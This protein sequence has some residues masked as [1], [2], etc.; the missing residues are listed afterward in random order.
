M[1]E[2][3]TIYLL[4][5]LSL[6]FAY[7]FIAQREQFCFSGGIKDIILFKH[8]RR[9]ASL[10]VAITT[11][12]IFTQFFSWYLGIDF[13]NTRYFANINYLFIVLGGLLFGYG[14]MVSDGCSSR[15]LIKMAQGDKESFF[16]LIALG[17]FAFLT[18][19]ILSL[20]GTQIYSLN[21]VKL[22][23]V[24][25]AWSVP[26]LIV[27]IIVSFLLYKSLKKC[28]HILQTWDGFLIGL[29]ITFGWLATYYFYNLLFL[30]ERLQSL[31]F[32]YPLG[33]SIEFLTSGFSIEILTMFPVLT[34]IGV[35]LGAFISAKTN[36]KYSKKQMC[37]NSYQ[38]PPKLPMKLF[39]GACMGV[40]GILAVGC[41]VGQGLSGVST[42]SLASLVAIVSIYSSAYITAV[43]MNKKNALIA[44]FVF[45]FNTK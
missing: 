35:I 19:K 2:E 30:E 9:T 45:D 39:G 7:G 16:I 8:T 11:T 17:L 14:M 12:V 21:I 43:Y 26:F 25:F 29:L 22:F 34:M 1:F 36:A 27:M 38:N 5:S 24:D 23:Q 33:K 31:S 41:T 4:L 32:V 18:Y 40:G 13:Q 37:D 20:F 42:L 15:H 28:M 3:T 6:G 10:I 44:C